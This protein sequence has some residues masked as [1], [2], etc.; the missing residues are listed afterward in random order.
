MLA[1]EYNESQRDQPN[2]KSGDEV[3]PFT[4]LIPPSSPH[5]PCYHSS[6]FAGNKKYVC[7]IQIRRLTLARQL[8]CFLIT[9]LDGSIIFWQRFLCKNESGELAE[10]LSAHEPIKWGLWLDQIDMK[11]QNVIMFSPCLEGHWAAP[12]LA[13][14]WAPPCWLTPGCW[15]WSQD[16]PV[17][18]VTLITLSRSLKLMFGCMLPGPGKLIDL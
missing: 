11:K 18:D 7:F 15:H 1:L 4:L 9:R 6:L 3:S 16:I 13:L 2:M 8:L 5:F 10:Q 14:F 12:Q 17:T